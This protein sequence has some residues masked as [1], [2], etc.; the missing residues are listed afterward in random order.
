MTECVITHKNCALF[1]NFKRTWLQV[2]DFPR[3]R[4]K[5]ITEISDAAIPEN[6]KRQTTGN[7]SIFNGEL[8][9][10]EFFASF[11]GNSP[12]LLQVKFDV[13]VCVALS[14][15]FVIGGKC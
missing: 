8:S 13:E 6:T 2:Q 7:V 3:L 11:L 5:K 10:T 9:K 4:R 1:F 14:K 15:M 12:F